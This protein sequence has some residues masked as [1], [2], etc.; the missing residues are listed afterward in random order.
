VVATQLRA[1]ITLPR[2]KEKERIK[3][4]ASLSQQLINLLCTLTLQR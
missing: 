3:A 4:T 1:A 2:V